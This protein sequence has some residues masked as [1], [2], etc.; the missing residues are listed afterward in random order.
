MN[1]K[2]DPKTPVIIGV[3]QSLDRIDA[4]T[5]KAWS[6][7]DLA[8]E[9]ARQ[10]VTDA[11]ARDDV[12]QDVE[13]IATTRTFEDSRPQ[14]ALFGKSSNFPRSITKRLGINPAYA[15]WGKAGGNSPQ[16]LVNEFSERIAK[17]EFK[18]AL[19]T[20]AEAISTVRHAYRQGLKLDFSEDPG[21][22]VE[23]RGSGL[24]ELRDPTMAKYGLIDPAFVY[25]V[26]ENARRARLGQT[27]E[28]YAREMGDLFAP[29]AAIASENPKSAWEVPAYKPDELITVGAHNRWIAEPYPLR[30][31]AR[32]QVNLGAAV[33]L[34]SYETALKLGVPEQRLVYLHG[35]AQATEKPFTQRPDLGASPASQA[36]ARRAM[37]LAGVTPDDVCAFDFYSCFPIAVSNTAIDEF[38]LSA[39]DLRGLSVTGGLPF[40]GG[41][42]NNYSMHAIA[43]IVA[44]V[45]K[46]GGRPG[47]VGANGGYLSKYSAG[48]YST[49]PKPW[50]I[51]DSAPLQADLNAVPGLTILPIYEGQGVVESYTVIHH[52]DQPTKAIIMGRTAADERFIA[53]SAPDDQATP[54]QAHEADSLHKNVTVRH[55]DGLNLFQF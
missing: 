37:T 11:Q 15:V 31:V 49:K 22:Q 53:C 42:G 9:A 4:K 21:G 20:G 13:V 19:I 50:Q 25:A 26:A 38:G 12:W 7:S 39:H 28:N 36:V 44:H 33:L 6:A 16:D 18:A 27:R 14:P 24:Q 29:L 30:L 54:Q 34:A 41:P 32:D 40:F 45:R 5:Y 10:A 3:G 2:I 47:F 23:D 48:V 8:A 1:M 17:G 46:A 43:E 35:Y 55:E 52:K 51:C